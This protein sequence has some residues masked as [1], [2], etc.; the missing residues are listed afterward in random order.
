MYALLSTFLS[1]GITWDTLR[2]LRYTPFTMHLL[3]TTDKDGAKAVLAIFRNLG[4]ISSTFKALPI[5][6]S[7]PHITSSTDVPTKENV[8]VKLWLQFEEAEVG[9]V[10][11]FAS[12]GPMLQKYWLGLFNLFPVSSTIL[13]IEGLLLGL[14]SNML[15]IVFQSFFESFLCNKIYCS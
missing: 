11:V 2:E 8:E 13:S 7:I 3:N 1:T 5:F 14:I 6:K 10:I 15:C 12:S 4:G 9:G